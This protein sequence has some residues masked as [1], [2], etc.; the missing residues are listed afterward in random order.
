MAMLIQRTKEHLFVAILLAIVCFTTMG[1]EFLAEST[2]T[3]ADQS[4]LPRWVTLPPGFARANVVLTMSYY[5][6]PWGDDARF[7]LR[8][9]NGNVMK[10]I[11][12]KVRCEKPFQLKSP[13][14]QSGSRYPMY[15][16]ITVNG[17]TE[18]IEHRTMEPIFYVTDDATVWK[19]Y[20][21]IGCR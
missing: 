7:I 15:E 10:K 18:I 1:C 19:Q 3:L 21:S 17:T 12:G 2:F 9:K 20:E 8:D 14:Q 16:P 13:L 6:M 5:T 4:R 11:N